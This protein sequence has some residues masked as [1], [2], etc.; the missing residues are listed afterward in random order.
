[1]PAAIVP[2]RWQK[3]VEKILTAIA[4]SPQRP[5]KLILILPEFATRD[6]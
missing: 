6:T 1:M 3:N 5:S 2:L 4:A